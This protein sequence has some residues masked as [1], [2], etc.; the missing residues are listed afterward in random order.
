MSATAQLGA[1]VSSYDTNQI[2]TLEFDNF[3]VDE[4]VFTRPAYTAD[5]SGNISIAAERPHLMTSAGGRSWEIT[6]GTTAGFQNAFEGNS[7]RAM[8][9][10]GTNAGD[11]TNGPQLMYQVNFPSTGDWY[12]SLRGRADS[13]NDDSVHIALDGNTPVTYGSSGLSDGFSTSSNSWNWVETFQ[14]SRVRVN[15][16][17]AGV[18]NLGIWMREDGVA[19]DH[20]FLSK[21]AGATKPSLGFDE[22]CYTGDPSELWGARYTRS[23]TVSDPTNITFDLAANDAYRLYIDG[24]PIGGNLN[25]VGDNSGTYTPQT[26]QPGTHTIM[27]EYVARFND[28]GNKLRLAYILESK[29]FHTDPSAG[30]NYPENEAASVILEGEIDLTNENNATLTWWDRYDVGNQDTMYVEINTVAGAD[31]AVGAANTWTELYSRTDHTNNEWRKRLVD[32]TPYVGEKVVIRF[33]FSAL[34]TDEERDGW[35]IDDVEVS[36]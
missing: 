15:V 4:T 30:G 3:R 2:F 9:N 11:S 17:T 35:Y 7:M 21:N 22:G 16:P 20:I 1:A 12:V 26:L 28:D 18:H 32:L 31:P 36:D 8:P 29:V 6:P 10:W 13:G 24:L 34:N 14:G 5:A 23:V 27:I 25:T 19:V 33:R